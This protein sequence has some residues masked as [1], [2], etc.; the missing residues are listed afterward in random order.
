MKVRKAVITAGSPDQRNL[1]LQ[2]L[3]DGDGTEKTVLQ[4]L[5]EEALRANVEEVAIIVQPGDETTFS[6]VV[7]EHAHRIR[8]I[9]Q[10]E[11]RGY[12]HALSLG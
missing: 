5:F 3:I 9:P 6:K 4:I 12:G 1:P 10:E 2:T 7:P 11:P 8:F